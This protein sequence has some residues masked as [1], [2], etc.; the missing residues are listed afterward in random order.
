MIKGLEV[1]RIF[2]E[3]GASGS[4]PLESRPVGSELYRVLH[5]GDT[6]IVARLDRAFRNAADAL[7]KADSWKRTGIRLIVSDMGA[8][9]VTDNGVAK[10]FFGMLALVAEFERERILERT[11]DGRRAKVERGGHVGGSARRDRPVR[12][13]AR[14][15]DD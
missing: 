9:P 8:D 1:A 3:P 14:A 6:L 11:K 7:A 13:R 2:E 12:S 5:S 15:P 10:L 4:T